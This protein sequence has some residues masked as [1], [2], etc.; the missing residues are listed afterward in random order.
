MIFMIECEKSGPS[1]WSGEGLI[2]DHVGNVQEVY[3]VN[4]R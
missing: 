3:G 1:I 2:E 4:R